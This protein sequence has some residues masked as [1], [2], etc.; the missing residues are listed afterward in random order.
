ACCHIW[1]KHGDEK[2]A[3][4]AG[5]PLEQCPKLIMKS[6]DAPDPRANQDAYPVGIFFGDT[7][8]GIVER[9]TCGSQSQ[10]GK[11]SVSAHLFAILEVR[12][13]VESLDLAGE[14]HLLIG[15]IEGSDRLDP[16]TAGTERLPGRLGVIAYWGNQTYSRNDDSS[17]HATTTSH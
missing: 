9:L 13:G 10:V 8:A 11:G 6:G 15:G 12:R 3:D 16:R 4:S 17:T 5:S 7:E 2:R 14:P 1:Y